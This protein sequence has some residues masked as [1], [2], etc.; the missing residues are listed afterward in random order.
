MLD[1]GEQFMQLQI[2]YLHIAV[3]DHILF[4]SQRLI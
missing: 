1:H 3:L 4:S 2:A